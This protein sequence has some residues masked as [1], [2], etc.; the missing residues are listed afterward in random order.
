MPALDVSTGGLLCPA[1]LA[2]TEVMH[3]RGSA[4][5]RVALAQGSLDF[6]AGW[7][8]GGATSAMR[9][10]LRLLESLENAVTR[11]LLHHLER[12]PKSLALLPSLDALKD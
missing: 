9:P 11:H 12:P 7:R 4:S 10:S 5:D 6:L 1:C 3:R 2:G 8:S